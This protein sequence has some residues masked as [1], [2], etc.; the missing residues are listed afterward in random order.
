MGMHLALESAHCVFTPLRDG[1]GNENQAPAPSKATASQGITG[2]C[3][4]DSRI[5][6]LIDVTPC[7]IR[8]GYGGTASASP[9]IQC[10]QVCNLSRRIP[11]GKVTTGT[12]IHELQQNSQ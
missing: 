11:N 1:E 4:T 7:A 10:T 9:A 6:Q 8:H 5:D 12:Q 2:H 3:L